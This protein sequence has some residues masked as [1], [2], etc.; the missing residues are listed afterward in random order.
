LNRLGDH[1]PEY[2]ASASG[3]T[4]RAALV[5]LAR[6]ELAITLVFDARNDEPVGSEAIAAIAPEAWPDARL[7]TVDAMR[8]LDL[9]Y[10][11]DDY[12]Q[13]VKRDEAH[14]P[15]R[16]ARRFL[17][18][19]RSDLSVRQVALSRREWTMLSALHDGLTL[20]A[21]VQRMSSL[22]PALSE[23]ELFGWFRDWTRMGLFAG[24]DIAGG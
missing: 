7:R 22:R 17:L 14:P 21:A 23:T 12:L 16:K 4:R 10:P 13:S 18:V 6:F 24:I 1:L 11:V 9:D 5:A 3:L 20:A 2:I 15:L 19:F 8:L